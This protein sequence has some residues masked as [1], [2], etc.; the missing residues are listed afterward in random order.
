MDV[1]KARPSVLFAVLLISNV[2]VLVIFGLRIKWLH[3]FQ[4]NALFTNVIC[5][6]IKHN[7]ICD[8]IKQNESKVEKYE[9]ILFFFS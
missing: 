9:N 8:A 4:A 3:G 5:D 2:K 1:Q 6:A 7:V